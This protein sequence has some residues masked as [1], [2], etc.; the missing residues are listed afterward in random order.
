M[1][2]HERNI[3]VY[4]Y[5]CTFILNE[6]L[7]ALCRKIHDFNQNLVGKYLDLTSEKVAE[8]KPIR[9]MWKRRGE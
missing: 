5:V 4:V 6:E 8:I 2:H 7:L 9:R 1:Q 3:S